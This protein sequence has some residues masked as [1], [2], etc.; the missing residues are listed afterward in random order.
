MPVI[1]ASRR[2]DIP[3]F[4]AEW[5]MNRVRA[6]F[7]HWINPYANQVYRVAITPEDCPA[8]VFWT[9]NPRPLMAHLPEL[10]ARGFKYYF[11]YTITGYPRVI[12]SHRPDLEASIAT[13]QELSDRIGPDFV[14]WRYDPVVVSS[15]TPLTY[16]VSYFADLARRLAGYTR[17]CVYSFLDV[18]NKTE[19]NLA[20]LTAQKGITFD[21]PSREQR[22]NLLRTMV[23]ITRANRMQLQ[24][25]CM[26]DF[27]NIDGIEQSHCVSLKTLQKLTADSGMTL[28]AKPTRKFCGCVASVDIGSYDTCLF[29]CAYCYATNSRQLALANQEAHDPNDS[30]LLRP[31]RLRGVDLAQMVKEP[32]LATP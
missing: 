14:T 10:D 22:H 29:G 25:C 13:F 2:T 26:D 12:E 16:H 1:S 27:Q 8:F 15:A 19:R 5:F 18:Y 20:A 21:P 9:R 4:Y 3:A 7:C 17:K 6:G 11:L 23:D 30:I 28:K 32:V 24:S 31:E